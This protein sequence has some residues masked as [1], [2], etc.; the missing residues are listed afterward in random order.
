[1]DEQLDVHQ[2]NI[3]GVIFLSYNNILQSGDFATIMPGIPESEI[4]SDSV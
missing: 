3:N 2:Q 1:M 4:K